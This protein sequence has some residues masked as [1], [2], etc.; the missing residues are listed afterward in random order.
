ML[1]TPRHDA[2]ALLP[3]SLLPD[4]QNPHWREK[5]GKLFGGR[6][7]IPVLPAPP[8]GNIHWGRR[9][10]LEHGLQFTR[11]PRVQNGVRALLH[12]LCTNFAGC[13]AKQSQQFR[14]PTTHV[15]VRPACRIALGLEGEPGCGIP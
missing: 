15:L 8:C 2:S 3:S 9:T 1:C 12:G 4:Q 14:C 10:Q 5:T 6:R 13:R 11:E 7:A